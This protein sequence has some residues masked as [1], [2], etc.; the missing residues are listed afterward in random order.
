MIRDRAEARGV[1]DR[2]YTLGLLWRLDGNASWARRAVR[3][4]LH[5]TSDSSCTSWNPSHFLDTAEMMH[6]V[7]VGYD[8][9][10]AGLE[11]LR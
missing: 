4:M 10:F 6:A 3:E 11:V 2:T 5:V 8:W 9:L 1:L 7:A